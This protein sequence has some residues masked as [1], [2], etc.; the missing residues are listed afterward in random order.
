MTDRCY[1]MVRGSGIRVTDLDPTGAVGDALVSYGAS[2]AVTSVVINEVTETGNNELLRND[3]D[4][5]RLHFVTSDQTI[6]YDADINFMRCDPSLLSIMT[7]V[8]VVTN[9][10]GDVVGFEADTRVPAKAFALEVWS[11]IIG[12]S[13][14]ADV[15]SDGFGLSP[16]GEVAFGDTG[17][18]AGGGTYD[19]G[20]G[21]PTLSGKPYGY[22]LFPFFKGGTV[23]G[24]SFEGGLVSFSVNGAR[25]QRGSK[26][27]V[28]PHDMEGPYQRLLTPVSRNTAWRTFLTTCPPP[29][30]I[31]GVVSFADIIDGNVLTDTLD[32][33]TEPWIVSGN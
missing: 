10:S 23:S 7:G 29:D 2:K 33:N 16:F 31:N 4:E 1:A 11:K 21:S 14:I 8:P 28:G 5:P 6:R 26:W 13:C 32:G 19:F 9:A 24:F 30:Q 20:D 25:T 27:G 18:V 3:E 17:L 12:Y 22:T 15:V